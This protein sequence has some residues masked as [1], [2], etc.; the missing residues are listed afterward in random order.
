MINILSLPL[1]HSCSSTY[2]QTFAQCHH[3]NKTLQPIDS[4][5]LSRLLP[6]SP[7][8][9]HSSFSFSPIQFFFSLSP[10]SLISLTP[11]PIQFSLY[12][13]TLL[14]VSHPRPPIRSLSLSPKYFISLFLP[15]Q[16]SFVLSLAPPVN[17]LSLSLPTHLS[18][19]PLKFSAAIVLILFGY[20]L[21]C[22]FD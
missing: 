21:R 18:P 1:S 12:L 10:Q 3:Q 15:N 22:S 6:P 16:F 17:S 2:W 20:E 4:L 7:P 13:P 11:S 9:Y 8:P 14:S 5:F 19:P